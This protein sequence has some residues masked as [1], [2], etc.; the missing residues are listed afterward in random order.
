MDVEVRKTL[1]RTG[2]SRM[3]KIAH[4]LCCWRVWLRPLAG[5]LRCRRRWCR[6]E[7]RRRRCRCRFRGSAAARVSRRL[8]ASSEAASESAGARPCG[9]R[10]CRGAF[11]RRSRHVV[12]VVR[13][14][15]AG[16]IEGAAV[17]GG[18]DF[19]GVG[20]V[21]LVGR[22]RTCEG[23]DLDFALGHGMLRHRF[24]EGVEMFGEDERLVALDVDVDVGGD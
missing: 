12:A 2:M 7:C 4:H 8:R 11:G 3:F 17:G 14:G 1:A 19:H 15:R 24:E 6:A 20:I 18:D 13:D 23:G 5:P 22:A 21:D 10:R 16:K 9:R